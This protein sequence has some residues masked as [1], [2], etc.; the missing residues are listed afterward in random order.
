M[1]SMLTCFIAALVV[2]LSLSSPVRAQV[3][4]RS[5]EVSGNIGFSNLAGV[6][7]NKHVAF[8]G[9]GAYNFSDRGTLGAEY[10]YQMMGSETI[11]GVTGT[12]RIQSYG[13]VVRAYLTKSSRIV[14]YMVVAGGG[15]SGTVVV[16]AQGISVSA[17]QNGFYIG[18][19]GGA[20]IYASPNWG[21]RP[22]FRYERQQFMSTTISGIAIASTGENYYLGT[23]SVFYQWGGRAKK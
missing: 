13:P 10:S 3:V 8:G 6:D 12:A 11:G 22:E 9:A 5:G 1:R 14:P 15:L 21:I 4:A 23:V 19:G 17:T 18:F 16:S 7:G 20:S 2:L